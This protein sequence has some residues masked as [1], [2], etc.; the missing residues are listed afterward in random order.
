MKICAKITSRHVKLFSGV[1]NYP[2]GE[3]I[4]SQSASDR[5]PS[6]MLLSQKSSSYGG[7]MSS[8]LPDLTIASTFTLTSH[9]QQNSKYPFQHSSSSSNPADSCIS[10]ND[11]QPP[12]IPSS[13]NAT[14][15]PYA[16]RLPVTPIRRSTSMRKADSL[17]RSILSATYGRGSGTFGSSASS[18]TSTLTCTGEVS[19]FGGS[20]SSVDQS[21]DS[22]HDIRKLSSDV[23]IPSIFS[24]STSGHLKQAEFSSSTSSLS[25]SIVNQ[26]FEMNFELLDCGALKLTSGEDKRHSRIVEVLAN[27][28]ILSI[29]DAKEISRLIIYFYSCLSDQTR[30]LCLIVDGRITR[31]N[32]LEKVAESFRIVEDTCSS[33][34]T[35]IIILCGNSGSALFHATNFSY[36]PAKVEFYS[37]TDTF[38][39]VIPKEQ[40]T[41]TFNGNLSNHHEEWVRF[42]MKLEPYT[43][44]C[45]LTLK[46][47]S[48]CKMMY[49][50][51]FLPSGLKELHRVLKEHE[52][53]VGKLRQ[54][55]SQCGHSQIL[56]RLREEAAIISEYPD[57][58]DAVVAAEQLKLQM[59]SEFL[60]LESS[61]R[62][63]VTAVEAAI[64][65]KQFTDEYRKILSWFEKKGEVFLE[66]QELGDTLQAL[67]NAEKEFDRFNYHAMKYCEKAG[68]IIEEASQLNNEEVIKKCEHLKRIVQSFVGKMDSRKTRIEHMLQIYQHID[69]AIDWALNGMHFLAK[70]NMDRVHSESGCLKL[71]K[72]LEKYQAKYPQIT[73]EMFDRMEAL[74]SQIGNENLLNQLRFARNRC[75]NIDNLFAK[76]Q[77]S[78]KKSLDVFREVPV[79][80]NKTQQ[81]KRS[82]CVI[83]FSRQPEMESSAAED[84]DGDIL[85]AGPMLPQGSHRRASCFQIQG[86]ESAG[87][88]TTD[89]GT[90]VESCPTT[91]VMS[92]NRKIASWKSRNNI[93]LNIDKSESEAEAGGDEETDLEELIP[94]DEM[95]LNDHGNSTNDEG[96]FADS[97]SDNSV[98]TM[99]HGPVASRISLVKTKK[100]K[101]NSMSS[102]R[103]KRCHSLANPS[104]PSGNTLDHK[105]VVHLSRTSSQ[106]SSTLTG[107]VSLQQTP[108]V[109]SSNSLNSSQES[110]N[111]H[112]NSPEI[113][114]NHALETSGSSVN[115]SPISKSLCEV[116]DDD[117]E[118]TSASG[119]SI[120]DDAK[121]IQ[122]E[123]ELLEQARDELLSTSP[124][125]WSHSNHDNNPPQVKKLFMESS[126]TSQVS[127]VSS[128]LKHV[129]AE[130]IQSERDYIKSLEYIIV[131]YCPE[132]ESLDVPQALRGKRNLVFGNVEKFYEFHTFRF[133]KE[134][135]L[136]ASDPLGVGA[137]FIRYEREFYMY[138]LYNQNKPKSDQIMA[139]CG[140]S[141]FSRRQMM[142]NDK[143]NLASYLLK[144]TQRLAKYAL[145]LQ[146]LMKHCPKGH[147]HESNLESA[148]C[149]VKFLLRHG[150]DLLALESL[151]DCD[152]ELKDYGRLLRQEE[153]LV[154]QGRKK[155][156]RHIFLFEDLLLFSKTKKSRKGHDFYQYKHSLKMQDI[157]LTQNIGESGYRFEIWFRRLKAGENY[158]IQ[159]PTSEIKNSWVNEFT[160]L[161][162]D[163]AKK[164]RDRRFQEL[165]SLGIGN[166]PYIDINPNADQIKDRAVNNYMMNRGNKIRNSVAVP[167]V[168]CINA[169]QHKRP[170]SLISM[171]SGS[172]ASTLSSHSSSV[173]GSLTLANFET[174]SLNSTPE[175]RSSKVAAS[176]TSSTLMYPPGYMPN[177]CQL[178]HSVSAI[179]NTTSPA[180]L[181]ETTRGIPLLKIAE[182]SSS[183]VGA[184]E[185][186]DSDCEKTPVPYSK[187]N[188]LEHE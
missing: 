10:P 22:S 104:S 77:A 142:L 151:K 162:W 185:T 60:E 56:E 112:E 68:D 138:A 181:T 146:D 14:T 127:E 41:S 74:S 179:L 167:S 120:D 152:L 85:D 36:D 137:A 23:G 12:M 83:Q 25:D 113:S 182:E 117:Y 153:F 96:N 128:H 119:S 38:Y 95:V 170:H 188:A 33:A 76:R 122:L 29:T 50:P 1:I 183:L 115:Y 176:T 64:A 20:S 148:I 89:P 21:D 91:P 145:L 106:T 26:A 166:K 156:M 28:P 118:L 126:A 144:P 9:Q 62:S 53:A 4:L 31:K 101:N 111:E 147:Q 130:I 155:F 158:V 125:S 135:E 103:H 88:T 160:K 5:D 39:A 30:G 108:N 82:S 98:V 47:I 55:F 35:R 3:V 173:V 139:E 15:V 6:C 19:S 168:D 13:S 97:D 34:I 161:L 57:A 65:A 49:N 66:H 86:Y 164:K 79:Y 134:L 90:D 184:K 163:Q 177:P 92:R 149:V 133:Q 141:F 175:H 178:S 94:I 143:M 107:H 69:R 110:A 123:T 27:N 32:S 48:R 73:D 44:S 63:Y 99:T 157:G 59:S 40:L 51:S 114:V 129:I 165:E 81:S 186:P 140:N 18:R 172:S 121:S 11:E 131:N 72:N 2:W 84:T 54:E 150:N 102:G 78:I 37:K 46:Q 87:T 174:S 105:A 8:S 42:R 116:Q 52:A 171:S 80:V 124:K 132:V 109:S 169:Q 187:R 180:K 7:L 75:T 71:L 67:M 136:Y 24:R 45:N 17:T 93:S 159:A 100:R 43:N 58:F 70:M 154:Y 16:M 61:S